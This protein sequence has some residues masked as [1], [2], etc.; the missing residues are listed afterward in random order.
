M[1]LLKPISAAIS[2]WSAGGVMAGGCR[3][4]PGSEGMMVEAP[5]VGE[6]GEHGVVARVFCRVG[7]CR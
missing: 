2:G 1:S 3:I 4:G 5:G 6:N 7:E